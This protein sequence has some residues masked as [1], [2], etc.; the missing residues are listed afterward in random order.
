M[1]QPGHRGHIDTRG[2]DSRIQEEP[3]NGEQMKVYF[4]TIGQPPFSP[5]NQLYQSLAGD[6]KGR[7]LRDPE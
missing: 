6:G 3:T 5:I 2:Q 1:A 7:G 4:G